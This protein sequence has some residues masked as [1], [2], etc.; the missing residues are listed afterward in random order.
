VQQALERQNV[1]LP[2]GRLEGSAVELSLRTAGRLETEEDFDSM[3]LREDGGRQILLRDVG[4]AELGAEELRSGN[5][6]GG[7][8][9]TGVAVIPQP[10]TNAIAIADEFYR[11][12]DGIRA[13][14]PE[15]YE[16]EVG[17][18]FT[19]FVRRSI[20]EVQETIG[21]A[22]ALVGVIIFLFLRDW[23]AT[24]I[25]VVAIPVS[26]VA[27][28]FVM[29]LAGFTINVLTLVG[30]VL[31]I[32]LV[33]DDAIVVL[34]NV[35]A[36]VEEGHP[37]LR[38]ALEGSREIYF[39][40]IATTVTLVAVFLPI[41]FLTGLTG[42][43]FR[44][45]GVVVAGAVAISAF[46]AL[47]LT[48]MMCR[49]ALRDHAA[50]GRFH[51]RTQPFFD[52]LTDRYRR[53]LD[54]FLRRGRLAFGLL[55][56][57]V[58]VAA[59]C[60]WALPSE[61]APLED[62]SNIRVNVRA[63]EG[64]S[65]EFTV[66]EMDRIAAWLEDEV[67]EIA[68]AFAISAPGSGGGAVNTGVFSIY[69]TDPDQR[70]RSQAE[71]FR[72]IAAG[73]DQFIGVRAFPAQPPTIGDRRAGQ[74]V[75]Y[76]LQAPTLEELLQV[77]PRF[78]EAAGASP[79]LRFVD[80]DLKVN[81]PEGRIEIDRRRA[82]ELG[83]SVEDIA[84][85]LGLAYGGQR[86][87]WF[88]KDERQYQVIGQVQRDD[89]N[90]P[91][92]L[93]SLFVRARG[94]E[95][96]SLDNLVRLDE[97][98]APAAIYRYNRFTS[99]TIS[100]GLAPGATIGDGIAALDAIAAEQL[101]PTIRTA[102]AGQSQDYADAGASLLFAFGLALALIYLVLAAQFESFRDPVIILVTVPLS[103]AGALAGLWLTGQTLNVFSQIGLI[104]L[105]GLV[106]K[107]GILIVEF[108]NQERAAG[109]DLATAIREASA[110]RLRPILMTT[111]STVFGILPIALSLG[112]A[113]GSRQSLGI[114][115]VAGLV[116][117]TGLT[118]YVVP[119]VYAALASRRA[120]RAEHDPMLGG[121]AAR[122]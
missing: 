85:T 82:A 4:Y 110:A 101:P 32:G 114:A 78:L 102:L 53:S 75:Q 122:V 13:A 21:I 54:A 107:N 112:G 17:Y 38:A 7:V 22:F 33:V 49:Y 106:T 26:I 70:A 86:F 61:L 11:R 113:A 39:A 93:A 80:A 109:R 1:D 119:A 67:P 2:S 15:D 60:W 10:N 71:I 79:V 59:L 111:F 94:G 62:R 6:S 30:V 40:V 29:Y 104:M 57:S 35:Y 45:F 3:I 37:P 14:A 76:V 47:S 115:V 50:H 51:A 41:V 34:E 108:A 72:Q 20:T 87:G 64:A 90:D 69:L 23:R 25:P 12:L 98:V 92:D 89:R 96:V 116:F 74:P 8:P 42:R 65:Y 66:H 95:M 84:R 83:V 55:A 91:G 121:T 18:D 88:L 77:L 5:K 46:V 58:A 103:L 105:I 100:A 9:V 28:F 31:A 117:S 19:K 68:R 97:R 16:I 118:L 43:L 73:L 52:A 120:R 36:K 24:L 63:P 56:A 99:A 48:P 44:E 81:R 27:T